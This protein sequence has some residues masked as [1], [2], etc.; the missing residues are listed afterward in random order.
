MMCF[1]WFTVM[2]C[3]AAAAAE[4]PKLGG[5][6]SG[7]LGA[8]HLKLHLKVGAGGAP[9]GTLDSVDQGAM[10]LVCANF[11]LA[12]KS[13]SFE[14]PSVS[15]KWHGTVSEDG[16]R[17][18][19]SWSQG[20][21]MPLLFVRE[22]Q[23]AAAE[24][25]SRVDGIWLGTL[26]AGGAKLRIQVQVKSDRAG[27]EYCALDSLDQGAIGL[28]CDNVQFNGSHFSF[29]V[30][31][32]KGRWSGT[33]NESGNELEGAWSQGQDLP[34]RLTRQKAALSAKA[35]APPKYDAARPAA[36]VGEL[37]AVLDSDLASALQEGA[38]AA[39]HGR[40]RGPWSSAARNPADS[41]LRPG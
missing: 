15:G 8:L 3:L 23:F 25:P 13:L 36:Q 34:L 19:G 32:V 12:E 20:E 35:P 28:P 38:L 24:K 21:E 7:V 1:R 22:A 27:K 5:E 17:L 33:L 9:E 30:P 11:R 31:S 14:V 40:R 2:L 18:D 29:E 41:C 37:K 6:Y 4:T 26:E 16:A 39:R 10:G